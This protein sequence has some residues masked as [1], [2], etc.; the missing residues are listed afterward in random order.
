MAAWG[1]AEKNAIFCSALTQG[2]YAM[3]ITPASVQMVQK[4]HR[5]NTSPEY[6]Q[7]T[8]LLRPCRRYRTASYST[9]SEHKYL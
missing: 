1:N 8:G 9:T 6:D 5:E 4:Y 7:R 3:L 2:D